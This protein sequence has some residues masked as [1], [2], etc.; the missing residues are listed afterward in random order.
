MPIRYIYKLSEEGS[1]KTVTSIKLT[2]MGYK[3]KGLQ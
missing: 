3:K 2:F 1:G